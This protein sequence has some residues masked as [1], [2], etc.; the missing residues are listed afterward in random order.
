MK[1]KYEKSE[2]IF[3]LDAPIKII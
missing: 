2:A 1:D 3:R